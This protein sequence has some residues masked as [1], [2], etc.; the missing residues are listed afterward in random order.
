MLRDMR[1]AAGHEDDEATIAGM[2][3]VLAAMFEGL[4]SR[5][6]RNPDLDRS[7]VVRLFQGALRD[8]LSQNP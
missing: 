7:V 2:V 3:E 8:L 1:R 4:A 5:S 6:I